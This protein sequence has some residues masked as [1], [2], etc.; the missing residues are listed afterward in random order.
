MEQ[1]NIRICI[2]KDGFFSAYCMDHPSLFGSG[3]SPDEAIAELKETLSLTK[4][5]GKDSALVYPEWLDKEYV[6]CVSYEIRSFLEYYSGIITPATLS[7]L[8]GIHPKQIWSY[9]HGRSTPRKEQVQRIETAVHKFGQELTNI[10]L[11]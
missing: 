4:E 8:T 11:G 5:M 3:S 10:S 9:L 7:R 1:V 2:A 6:F